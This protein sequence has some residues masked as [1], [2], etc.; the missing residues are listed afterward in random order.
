MPIEAFGRASPGRRRR[1]RGSGGRHSAIL[2]G[3]RC[4]PSYTRVVDA[5]RADADHQAGTMID[6][7]AAITEPVTRRRRSISATTPARTWPGPSSTDR[8]GTSGRRS[9]RHGRTHQPARHGDPPE[10]RAA[11]PPGLHRSAGLGPRARA[12]GPDPGR[13]AGG[14][15]SSASS[16]SSS[17]RRGCGR[18]ARRSPSPTASSRM[19]RDT[20]GRTGSRRTTTCTG[21]G[22]RLDWLEPGRRA[23][24]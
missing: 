3:A 23:G 24:G 13:L 4:G 12:A 20:D 8:P 6:R 14:R 11:A 19:R 18:I 16:R 2:P 15:S 7:Y 17:A 21:T 1:V 22:R 5:D 10:R 9:S